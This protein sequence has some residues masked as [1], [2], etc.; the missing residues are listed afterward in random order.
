MSEDYK[1]HEANIATLSRT[2]IRQQGEWKASK[3]ANMTYQMPI[4][5]NSACCLLFLVTIDILVE[6]KQAVQE[7]VVTDAFHLKKSFS[8]LLAHEQ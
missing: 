4:T 6:H 7:Y 8:V 3:C 2:H 5:F 1:K